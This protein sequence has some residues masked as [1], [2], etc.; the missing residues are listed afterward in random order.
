MQENR[1]ELKTLYTNKLKVAL[2][3]MEKTRLQVKWFLIAVF[4]LGIA[5]WFFASRTDPRFLKVLIVI[6]GIALT[7]LSLIMSSIKNQKYRRE[8]KQKVVGEIVRLVNPEYK[9]NPDK[10]IS[11]KDFNKSKLF[12]KEAET[13]WC[14]DHVSGKVGEIPFEFCELWAEVGSRNSDDNN[15]IF[16]GIFFFAEFNKKIKSETYVLPDTAERLLGKSGQM[17]QRNNKGELVKLE[18]PNFERLFAV[19]GTSQNE[20]RYILTPRM[21]EAMIKIKKQ[22]MWDMQFSFIGKRV[23]CA[24]KIKKH[25]FEPAISRS[26]V[27]YRDIEEMHQLLN[28]AQIIIEEMDLNTM[29]WTKTIEVKKSE[30]SAKKE[31]LN[32]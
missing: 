29:I 30:K 12:K 19:F 28:L 15:L 5:T 6:F 21:M 26:G 20:A 16:K 32:P 10:S 11:L 4:V 8:Y 3:G 1:N 18:N 22:F 27:N 25:L 2:K 17:L 31:N 13:V 9:Y 14:D 7:L 24:V 23:Y